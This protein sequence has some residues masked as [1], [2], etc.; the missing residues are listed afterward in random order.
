MAITEQE[1]RQAETRMS[2]V[3]E[4]RGEGK[5]DAGV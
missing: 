4:A 2:L 3:R 1:L 5:L